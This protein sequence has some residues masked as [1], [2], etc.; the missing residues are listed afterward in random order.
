M[1]IFTIGTN[2]KDA[3][4]FFELLEKNKISKVID[5]R[6]NN[7]TQL[8]GFTKMND[9][10]FLLK[11]ILNIDYEYLDDL[12]P[13]KELMEEFRKNKNRE[14]YKKT[15]L[16]LIESRKI[17]E[18][19]KNYNFDRSCFLCSEEKADKCHRK[20]ISEYLFNTENIINL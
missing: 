10:K 6:L 5:I 9:L 20:L 4:I 11:K 2:K 16:E 7:T 13:T 3:E 14:K 18:K 1:D 17:K 15:Y 19:Y 8:C 12:A